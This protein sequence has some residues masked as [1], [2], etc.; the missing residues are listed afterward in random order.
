[1]TENSVREA[2]GTNEVPVRAK[3][4]GRRPKPS[5]ALEKPGKSLRRTQKLLKTLCNDGWQTLA[6]SC[7]G[8]S[9]DDYSAINP[10]CN[11]RLHFS[12]RRLSLDVISDCMGRSSAPTGLGEPL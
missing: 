5:L 11:R 9:S 6:M 12:R 7:A 10:A 1:V 8:P 3:R 2:A 4:F